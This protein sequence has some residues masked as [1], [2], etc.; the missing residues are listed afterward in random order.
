ML[1]N[2]FFLDDCKTAYKPEGFKD[3]R[4][5]GQLWPDD[6]KWRKETRQAGIMDAGFHELVHS[7]Q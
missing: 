4:N 5:T 6:R 3:V 7:E 2:L 1:V